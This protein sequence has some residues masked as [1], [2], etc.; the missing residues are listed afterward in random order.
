MLYKTK[1]RRARNSRPAQLC[2]LCP[3]KLFDIILLSLAVVFVI[4][5]INE[6]MNRGFLQ[7]YWLI[8]ITMVLFFYYNYRKSKK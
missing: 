2:Y 8:M 5:S 1:A 7:S 6:I 4:I 3:M